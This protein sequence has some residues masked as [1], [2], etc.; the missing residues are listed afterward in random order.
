MGSL[1]QFASELKVWFS[2]LDPLACPTLVARAWQ[3]IRKSREW[4]FLKQEGCIFAP[5]IITLGTVRVTQFST[6][7]VADATAGPLWNAVAFTDPPAY[8]LTLRQFRVTGGS[9]YNIV[10]WNDGASTATLDR[11]YAEPSAS[12]SSYMVYQPYWP[13]PAV[14]FSRWLSLVDPINT[15]RF[16]YRNLFWTQKEVD[17]RDPGRFNYSLPIGLAAHDYVTLPGDSQARPRFEAWPHPVQQIGYVAEYMIEGDTVGQTGNIPR[18]IPDQVVMAR[19]RHYAHQVVAQQPNVDVKTKMY[20][21]QQAKVSD[22][23][24]YDL[25]NRAQLDDN[26]IFDARLVQEDN[27]PVLSGP[28]DA[29]YLQSHVVYVL[30]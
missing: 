16:R 22:A 18:Q 20:H 6:A 21:I 30:D 24:Y 4:S 25:L 7:V 10:A 26:S 29:D 11:P 3:D 2:S 12:G 9:V 13:A 15:Y 28:L 27:G 23:E 8:P 14:D 17:R 5:S 1:T 19:A